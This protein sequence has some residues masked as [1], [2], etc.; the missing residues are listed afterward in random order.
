MMN[1]SQ[2]HWA[3]QV[4]AVAL[5]CWSLA[6]MMT[7][8]LGWSAWQAYDDAGET[9]RHV[10]ARAGQDLGIASKPMGPVARQ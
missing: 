7:A 2:G 5:V 8:A 9:T 6:V 4:R 1:R 3:T 10:Q